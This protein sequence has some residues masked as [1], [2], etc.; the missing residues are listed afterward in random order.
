MEGIPGI[1]EKTITQLLQHFKS[2]K[3]IAAA[4]FEDLSK[5]I[6]SSRANKIV[7]H[8]QES[9]PTKENSSS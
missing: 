5:I 6:G 1:G 4:S 7:E 3:R 2:T 9:K 8:F